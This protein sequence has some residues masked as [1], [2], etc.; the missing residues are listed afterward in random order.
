MFSKAQIIASVCSI[1]DDDNLSGA[2]E[3]LRRD[4]PFTPAE[5]VERKYG[6]LQA[7]KVFLRDGFL[8]IAIPERDRCSAI[9]AF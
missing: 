2:G 7:L 8:S 5:T 9:L 6:D 4:Y 1:L 3:L